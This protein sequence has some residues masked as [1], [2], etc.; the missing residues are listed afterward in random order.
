MKIALPTIGNTLYFPKREM[1]R[2]LVID[3]SSSPTII[4]TSI[5]PELVGAIPFTVCRKS[6]RKVIE[7]NIA[8]PTM[9]PIAEL[10]ANARCVN[11]RGG[12]SGSG[13]RRSMSTNAI[14]STT[15]AV[16]R[17]QVWYEPHG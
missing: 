7:P 15:P 6:G 8:S 9:K 13:T 1:S 10:T 11:R 2:P 16:P 3:V 17:S 4:A 14:V 12:S 5:T